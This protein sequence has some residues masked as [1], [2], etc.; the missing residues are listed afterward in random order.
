[1]KHFLSNLSL[2][3]RQTAIDSLM[4]NAKTSVPDPV[5]FSIGLPNRELL[6]KKKLQDVY[7]SIFESGTDSY[8]NYGGSKGISPLLSTI[9]KRENISQDYIMISTGNTQGVE[10][11]A[12]L[13]LN[14][15][16]TIAF[17]SYTYAIAHSLTHQYNLNALEI[18]VEADGMNIE[19]LELELKK[20]PIKALYIIPN[21]NNP[22]GTTLSLNKRK[23]LVELAYQYDF[24]IIEDDPYRD[25]IFDKRLPSL[26]ELDTHKEKV[27]YLYSFSKTIAPT[28]RTGFILAH[29]FYIKKLEQFKQTTDSCTS[30]LNQM[31]VNEMIKSDVWNDSLEKQRSFYE[32]KKDLTKSFLDKMNE[33]YG[34][35]SNEPAG[36]LFYWVDTHAGDV[37]DWLKYAAK[38]GV[39]FIPG[40]AFALNDQS[41]T[42]FRLC[43]SYCDNEEMLKGFERIEQSFVQWQ[44]STT[45]KKNDYLSQ[46]I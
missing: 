37:T 2:N 24:L 45:L 3:T 33:K 19:Y 42:K 46:N 20:A 28:L 41:N 13:V 7:N 36:G 39:V 14:S 34:W 27:I 30:P 9:S 43:Y 8:F 31:V 25:L 44:Q 18:P 26:F 38:S 40:K 11:C 22:T 1:M 17:E 21:A 23:K 4:D 29:P 6:P 5:F 35:T 15:E 10:L 32:L 12:R 16:D